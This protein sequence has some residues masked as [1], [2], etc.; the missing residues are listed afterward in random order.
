MKKA[1]TIGS[2]ATN[3]LTSGN[4][5]V[6]RFASR[7]LKITI[8]A[9]FTLLLFS[10]VAIGGVNLGS[11][12]LSDTMFVSSEKVEEVQ[13]IQL[14]EGE[15][16]AAGAASSRYGGVT[17]KRDTL[18]SS[19]TT[20]T[21]TLTETG[22]VTQVSYDLS[23]YNMSGYVSWASYWAGNASNYNIYATSNGKFGIYGS[24]I[25]RKKRITMN[26]YVNF[27]LGD[28]LEKLAAAG[29]LKVELSGTYGTGN[30]YDQDFY[31][32]FKFSSTPLHANE[33]S[34]DSRLTGFTKVSDFRKSA[35][36]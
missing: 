9:V 36:S 12:A 26:A 14:G 10:I 7:V 15:L 28:V 31:A 22:N 33:N 16:V 11:D 24:G 25:V 19:T 2:K 27:E 35:G 20:L 18:S 29:V 32:G 6:K 8:M 5:A 21:T 4:D 3:L 34:G 13:A 30:G 23:G 1:T 17:T